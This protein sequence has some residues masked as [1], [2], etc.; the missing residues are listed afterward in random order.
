VNVYRGKKGN[1]LLHE[2]QKLAP[3]KIDPHVSQRSFKGMRS[4]GKIE[5]KEKER[6]KKRAGA[7]RSSTLSAVT[8]RSL[9]E[10]VERR[11]RHWYC[12]WRSYSSG[13]KGM[14]PSE[15]K[16][17]KSYTGMS[18]TN[19]IRNVRD[20]IRVRNLRGGRGS[21]GE[22]EKVFINAP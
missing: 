15:K 9:G 14:D 1:C 17:E 10:E 19:I 11:E 12:L 16:K 22:G 18:C 20:K 8:K 3:Q 13:V 4:G 6:A 2:K 7:A 5:R 21:R